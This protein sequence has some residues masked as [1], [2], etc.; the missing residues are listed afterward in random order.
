MLLAV[1]IGNTNVHVGVFKADAV[2]VIFTLG[3][4]ANRTADEYA[5]LF[6]SIL[7][8]RGVDICS[9]HG[10]VLGSVAPSVTPAVLTALRE[11]LGLQTVVIGPGVKTG[12]PIRLDDPAELGADLVANAAGAIAAVGAPVIVADFGTATTVIAIDGKGALQGGAI[13]SGVGMS[14][15]ALNGA[16]LLSGV[17]PYGAVTALGKNTPDCMRAG[18]VRGSAMAVTGFA[19]NYK[20]TL[21]LPPD[22]PLLVCGGFGAQMLS[23]LPASVR[24]VPTLTL[25]GLAA[26]Y[27][28]NQKQEI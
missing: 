9:L 14:L 12:F 16:E 20:K 6:K 23:Y 27:K 7:Q 4:V 2:S 10:A 24:Y 3:A 8:E 17:S 21:K 22:T 25:S 13:L 26:I 19:E 11:G 1:D 5:F 28:L 15:G 18:V